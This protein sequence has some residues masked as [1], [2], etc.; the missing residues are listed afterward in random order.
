MIES[1]KNISTRDAFG[2]ALEKLGEIN[3]EIVVIDGDLSHSTRAYLFANNH[4]ERFFN[5]GIAEQDMVSIGAGLST[6][7]KIPIV[8]TYAAFLVGRGLDQIRNMVAL[9]NFN[10][11]LVG[12]HSGLATGED[13]ATHQALEDIG[14]MR[15]IPQM[16][17]ISPA[18]AI[19][20]IQALDY[21][22]H[23]FGP[24]YLRLNREKSKII[25]KK[26]YCFDPTRAE[27]II[28][29][30]NKTVAL[31]ATGTMVS[32]AIEIKHLLEKE[33]IPTGVVNVH[34]IKP[35]DYVTIRDIANKVNFIFTLEDHNV[36]GGLGTAVADVIARTKTKAVLRKVG[37]KDTFGESGS[38]EE[39]YEKHGLTSELI[40]LRI[41]EELEIG[42]KRNGT[43][44]EI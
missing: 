18:D 16:T 6:C 36:I 24:F 15:G 43:S 19:E 7:G 38:L 31:L 14:I 13:G 40:F 27:I 25:H 41:L 22:I 44:N 33:G 3:E 2:Y 28:D 39:L 37:V 29:C 5:V 10:V 8:V 35:I 30:N 32:R 12:T 42:E 11:K 9:S 34:T 1:S 26:K 23:Q 21:I 4:P 17:V 20:V